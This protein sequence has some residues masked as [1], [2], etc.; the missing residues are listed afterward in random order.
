[1]L[2]AP[3][4]IIAF[5][6]LVAV[7]AYAPFRESLCQSRYAGVSIG[8]PKAAAEIALGRMFH[9]VVAPNAWLDAQVEY[10][11]YFWPVPKVWAV[12]VS[13]G[14]VIRKEILTSP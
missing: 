9:A 7:L 1:M 14:L 11:C 3:R 2:R 4:W 6:A 8:M 10:Q 5:A 12:G 13:D